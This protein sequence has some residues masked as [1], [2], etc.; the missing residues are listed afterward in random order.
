M[1]FSADTILFSMILAAAACLAATPPLD[2]IREQIRQGQWLQA[3][4]A[5]DRQLQNTKLPFE[6]R[7]SLLFEKE[8]MRR[9][10]LDF[11]LTK[12]EALRQFEQKIPELDAGLIAEWERKGIIENWVID[13]QKWYFSHA[14]DNIPRISKQAREK[15]GAEERKRLE[16][17]VPPAHL[18]EIIKKTAGGDKNSAVTKCY[19]VVYGITVHPGVVPPGET[20]RAWLPFPHRQGRQNEVKLL[21]STPSRHFIS[22]KDL[23]ISSVYLEKPA[24]SNTPTEF[25]IEF[26]YSVR[27]DGRQINPALVTPSVP[28]A[29]QK[30]AQE[31]APHLVFH[32]SIR[33]L[34]RS[35]V[36]S[37]TN[38]YLKTRRIFQW[39][40]ENIPWA[41]A[42]EYS[43]LDSLPLYALNQHHGDCGIQTMLFMALCRIEGIPAR[44]ESGWVTGDIEDMHDWCNVYIAPYG[45]VPVDVSFGFGLS[46]KEPVRWFYCGGIDEDRM[47]VNTDCSQPLYPSKTHM[48]SEPV[49][50]QRGEVEWRGGN[51]YYDA[52]DWKFHSKVVES[53]SENEVEQ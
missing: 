49:D 17:G 50:F 44:W 7:E 15:L 12:T 27:A 29:I 26:L 4:A 5:L 25:R 23:P 40:H 33:Q 16:R 36:G 11:C 2:G 32:E 24:I 48:R 3:E 9:I 53:F 37:E 52:W 21:S 8:K 43:T 42:R 31:Q 13:G 30:Y 39:V 46:T 18:E 45:W 22:P 34:A 41:T 38:V 35:I 47:V 1:S 20:I 6:E 14:A 19:R 28:L 10:R 51:L